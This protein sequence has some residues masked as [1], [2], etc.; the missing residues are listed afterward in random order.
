MILHKA[1]LLFLLLGF[2]APISSQ[3][4]LDPYKYIVVPKQYDFLKKENQY[5]VNSFTKYLFDQNGY[6]AFYQGD[7]YPDDLRANPCL[8]LTANVIDGSNAFTTKIVLVLKNCSG[9]VVL[10]TVEGKSKIKQYDKTY[11]DA[12]KKCFVTIEELDYKYDP[13]ALSQSAATVTTAENKKNDIKAEVAPVVAA[14]A[15]EKEKPKS[16]VGDV[17]T[18]PV[19]VTESSQAK[20]VVVAAPIA[21]KEEKPDAPSQMEAPVV[22]KSY[23]NEKITFLLV[24]QGAQLQAYVTKSTSE[25]YIQGELIGTF[26]KTSLP[27]VFRVAW[28]KP[29][30]DIDQTTAYFDESGDLKIDIHRDGKLEV[31]TFKEVK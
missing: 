1:I 23:K 11:I 27:N 26:E 8:G 30:K 19:P 28:K 20:V 3:N 17:K 15:A 31:L 21:V 4:E 7:D 18:D 14:G 12:L 5:R 29:E 6:Q 24:N 2:I 22:A 10:Q 16:T 25:K 13:K 9:E